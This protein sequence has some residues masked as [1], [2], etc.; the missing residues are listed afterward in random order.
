MHL[1]FSRTGKGEDCSDPI[2]YDEAST[3]R[4]E[5]GCIVAADFLTGRYRRETGRLSRVD[6]CKVSCMVAGADA[7][8]V[9]FAERSGHLAE[10]TSDLTLIV[11]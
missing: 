9:Q 5:S 3:K 11:L 6:T 10:T 7:K 1:R 2:L 4:R 8:V